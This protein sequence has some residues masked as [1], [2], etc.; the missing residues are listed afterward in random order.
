MEAARTDVLYNLT[1][2]M[3][4]CLVLCKSG[5]EANERGI[6]EHGC[7]GLYRDCRDTVGDAYFFKYKEGGLYLWVESLATKV[8]EASKSG[9]QYQYDAGELRKQAVSLL[10][11]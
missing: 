11:E 5:K 8:L 7:S 6:D 9:S 4:G 2:Q 3:C 10:P 1:N